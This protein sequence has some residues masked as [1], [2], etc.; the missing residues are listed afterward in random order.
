MA[1]ARAKVDEP[2][3]AIPSDWER[4]ALRRSIPHDLQRA[5]DYIRSHL[6]RKM[7]ID[8]LVA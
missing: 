7:S 4:L 8:E 2:K 6:H 1:R 3:L 5:I